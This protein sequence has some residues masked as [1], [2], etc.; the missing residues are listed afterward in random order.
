[1]NWLWRWRFLSQTCP[2]VAGDAFMYRCSLSPTTDTWWS[3]SAGR[4]VTWCSCH[5]DGCPSAN[6]MAEQFLRSACDGGAKQQQ[7]FHEMLSTVINHSQF[8]IR[9]AHICHQC[10][11]IKLF[12]AHADTTVNVC[13]HAFVP[14]CRQKRSCWPALCSA[15]NLNL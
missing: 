6:Q 10:M 4:M 15:I 12:C 14:T 2:H 8:R 7:R 9:P 1:M 5:T 11:L 3:Q 13:W